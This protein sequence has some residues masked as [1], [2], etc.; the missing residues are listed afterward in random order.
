[1]REALKTKYSKSKNSLFEDVIPPR[2]ASS[3]EA[4]P[5]AL[6]FFSMLYKKYLGSY[7]GFENTSNVTN[8]T[9]LVYFCILKEFF[10][11]LFI[12]YFKL[13]FFIVFRYFTDMKYK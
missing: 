13:I 12:I 11:K 2:F 7:L 6:S 8:V 10:K 3:L 9:I 1:M 5:S 4:F